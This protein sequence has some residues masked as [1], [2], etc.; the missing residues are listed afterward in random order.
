MHRSRFARHLCL[1]VDAKGYG[2]RDNVSQYDVQRDLPIA[3][4]EASEAAG[5]DRSVWWKQPQGD[6]EIAVLPPGQPEP[7]VVDDFVRE[8]DASLALLN[9]EK[10]QDVRLRLRVAIHFGVAYEAPS[11]FAGDAIV[12]TARLLASK[13]LHRALDASPEADMVVAL[14]DRVY[15]DTVLQ[16]HTSLQPSQFARVEVSEKEYLGPAW[17]RVLSRSSVPAADRPAA[18]NQPARKQ[19]ARDRPARE[20]P[21]GAAP[22]AGKGAAAFP[23]VEN[24]FYGEVRDVGVIGIR[25]SEPDW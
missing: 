25:F 18:R 17:I 21:A 4:A 2:G 7:R 10:R 1:A 23:G 14:S 24:N 8:L 16:R 6:G 13:E 19:P 5:L 11:G 3:L 9:H 20:Q 12:V 22:Q 15:A